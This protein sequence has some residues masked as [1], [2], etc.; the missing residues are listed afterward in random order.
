MW[1]VRKLR[2]YLEG[3]HYKVITDQMDLKWLISIESPSGRIEISYRKGQ[4]NDIA[5]A[6]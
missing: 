2:P 5:D 6:L 4:L 3:Y 1:A